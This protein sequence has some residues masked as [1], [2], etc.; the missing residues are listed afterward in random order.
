[1]VSLVVLEVAAAFAIITSLLMTGSWYVRGADQRSGLDEENLIFFASYTPLPSAP[2]ADGDDQSLADAQAR[3][4]ARVRAVPGV[5]AATPLSDSV[6]DER[7]SFPR[8]MTGHLPDGAGPAAKT[9]DGIGW[10]VY[11]DAELPRV[12]QTPFLSGG[13]PALSAAAAAPGRPAAAILTRCLARRLF[14]GDLPPPGSTVSS[15]ALAPTPIAGVVG[16]ITVR[17]PYLPDYRCGAFLLGGGP[18]DHEGRLLIRARSGQRDA[19]IARLD[20]TFAGDGARRFVRAHPYDSTETLYHRVGHGLVALLLI[21][22]AIVA[23]VSLLGAL[24]V[25]SFQVAERKRQIGIRRALGAT[26]ADIILYFLVETS[27]GAALGSLLGLGGAGALFLVMRRVFLHIA[28]EAHFA[29][30]TALALWLTSLLATLVPALRA[31]RVPP[32]VA[33]RSL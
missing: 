12:L 32:S 17:M 6:L 14:G 18:H 31:A 30:L 10:D 5:E 22:G 15:E 1:V 11:S 13:P 9:A 24:A 8:L 26:R 2:G 3:D 4:L 21:F 28:F 23:G 19:V 29:A 27:I 7:W 33:A 20:A 25:S 16:D